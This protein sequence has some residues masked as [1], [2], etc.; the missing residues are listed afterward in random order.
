VSASFGFM[1]PVATPPNAI[2]YGTG[3]IPVRSM[4]K[5]G[6]ALDILGV[7]LITLFGIYVVP[8]AFHVTK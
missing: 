8:W 2:V 6:F 3:R 1:L 5:F 4:M 7:I